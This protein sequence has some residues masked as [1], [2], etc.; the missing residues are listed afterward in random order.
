MYGPPMH[1]PA[2]WKRSNTQVVQQGKLVGRVHVPAVG[3]AYGSR[4]FAGI[5]LV[6]GNDPIVRARAVDGIPWGPLPERRGR[7]HPSRRDEQ[8]REARSVFLV[9]QLD[10]VT[11]EDRHR[12]L[13]L[14]MV[15]CLAKRARSRARKEYRKTR[16]R[17]YRFSMVRITAVKYASLHPAAAVASS[18]RRVVAACSS[19]T[20]ADSAS[21]R[22]YDRSFRM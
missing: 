21:W 12:Q 16:G 2:T 22:A 10:I 13:L 1:V 18:S 7:A 14:F 4:R 8:E 3:G 15:D 5:A 17:A 11:R 9:V 20:P 19:V 6:H